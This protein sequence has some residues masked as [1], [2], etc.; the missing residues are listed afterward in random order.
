MERVVFELAVVEGNPTSVTRVEAVYTAAHEYTS[1]DVSSIYQGDDLAALE[2][3]VDP[4]TTQ[5]RWIVYASAG[6]H[7][8]YASRARCEGRSTLYC[9]RES[10]S[11]ADGSYEL[12]LP[13]VHVGEPGNTGF[14]WWSDEST[15]WWSSYDAVWGGNEFCGGNPDSGD[16]N[17]CTRSIREKLTRNPFE[18]P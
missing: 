15:D 2:Y 13:I 4:V 16:R 14:I 3:S 8:T 6:K 5:P 11:S 17:A 10:C 7:A 9:A 18:S 1:F 12:L